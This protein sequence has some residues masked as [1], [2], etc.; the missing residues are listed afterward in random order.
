[1]SRHPP[2]PPRHDW[3][4]GKPVVWHRGVMRRRRGRVVKGW[5]SDQ[6]TPWHLRPKQTNRSRLNYSFVCLP[7]KW[8]GFWGEMGGRV[9]KRLW[10]RRGGKKEKAD[11]IA[12]GR[13]LTNYNHVPHRVECSRSISGQLQQPSS[14]L[15]DTAVFLQYTLK[16]ILLEFNN[17]FVALS[18]WMYFLSPMCCL[19]GGILSVILHYFTIWSPVISS[20][21]S[22]C[23]WFHGNIKVATN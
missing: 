4:G 12:D 9:L 19:S 3:E 21:I 22:Y 14:T 8:K 20:N 10:G 18:F 11:N 17:K 16:S 7:W 1:M 2:P 5:G 6:M 23:M 15:R 13:S